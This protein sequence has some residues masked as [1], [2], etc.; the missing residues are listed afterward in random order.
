MTGQARQAP[1][2]KL[3][4]KILLLVLGVALGT[5]A[6]VIWVINVN[7]TRHE[8]HRA[9][10]AISSAIQRYLDRVEERHA[11]IDRN[12]RTQ[13]ED[14]NTRSFLQGADEGDANAIRH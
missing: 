11:Q 12:L 2:M 14:P 8:T 3:S 9:N 5:S 7:V 1:T 4:T 10:A 13:L 6:L